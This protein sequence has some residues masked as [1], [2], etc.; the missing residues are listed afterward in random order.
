MARRSSV[1]AWPAQSFSENMSTGQATKLTGAVGE[2][3]VAAELGGG[4]GA[5]GKTGTMGGRSPLSPKMPLG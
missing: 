3:L 2:F 4:E 1:T 5:R